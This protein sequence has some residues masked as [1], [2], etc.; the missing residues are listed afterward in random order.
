MY[1]LR[2]R[3]RSKWL[4]GHDHCCCHYQPEC[5][6]WVGSCLIM[7]KTGQGHGQGQFQ[8]QDQNVQQ[9]QCYEYSQ[10]VWK[11]WSKVK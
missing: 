6:D 11:N 5:Q 1:N 4:R 3:S 9:G 7:K 2:S 10:G 8:S